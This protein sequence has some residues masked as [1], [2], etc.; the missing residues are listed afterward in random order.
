MG[1]TFDPPLGLL[2]SFL[3]HNRE[4]IA[5]DAEKVEQ[6]LGEPIKASLGQARS[7]AAQYRLISAA[8]DR[9][10]RLFAADARAHSK[11][12]LMSFL[13]RAPRAFLDRSEL[14]LAVLT[15]KYGA[16]EPAA[17]LSGRVEGGFPLALV[18]GPGDLRTFFRLI[19]LARS[20]HSL[21]G[22]R[23]LV[24]KG[25]TL[26][27]TPD[28]GLRVDLSPALRRAVDYYERRRPVSAL[29][30]S[31]GYFARA[32]RNGMSG[33][34]VPVV[35]PLSEARYIRSRAGGDL[36]LYFEARFAAF[37]AGPLGRL[38]RGYETPL[39]EAVRVSPEA[40]LHFL[41]ALTLLILRSVPDWPEQGEAFESDDDQLEPKLQFLFGLSRKGYLRMPKDHLADRIGQMAS[42][43]AAAGAQ[44]RRLAQE[45]IEALAIRPEEAGRID[46]ACPGTAPFLHISTDDH[47][48]IDLLLL[49]DFLAGLL[50]RCKQWYASQHGDRF[51]LDLKRWLDQAAPG[52]VIG[53][54]VPVALPGGSG[55]TD[56]DLLVEAQG[57]AWVV[58][59]KAFGKSPAFMMGDPKAVSQRRSKIRAA[60][61]QAGRTAMSLAREVRVGRTK[62]AADIPVRWLVCTPSVEWLHP[63]DEHGIAA[64]DIPAV[65]TPEE[66]LK[67]ISS[68]QPS[69][70][71]PSRSAT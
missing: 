18:V 14:L 38:L 15:A 69:R 42:P 21:Q 52:A 2:E 36:R 5:R 37:D 64:P 66:L 31:G 16:P 33:H 61:R 12:A 51:V 71:A 9:A 39:L 35:L 47:I 23:R 25:G 67:L 57:A 19:A 43:A 70:T 56:I 62:L 41:T 48:Y 60:V 1:Q 32:S 10:E 6:E 58:E 49:P 17:S 55:R 44:S 50:E 45:F 11:E 20:I 22:L 30:D 40:I 28:G 63:L 7:R 46:V 59:C 54:R 8:H 27:V 53:A 29:F 4:L 34:A 68:S 3:E 24:G 65:L 26:V 13:R